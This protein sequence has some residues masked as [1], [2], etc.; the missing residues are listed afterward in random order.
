MVVIVIVV[1]VVVVVVPC[2]SVPACLE[3]SKTAKDFDASPAARAAQVI[4]YEENA[5]Y[6]GLAVGRG[7]RE[8]LVNSFDPWLLQGSLFFFTLVFL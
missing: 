5:S 2:R 1:V 4:W 6:D 3:K 7:A 8:F